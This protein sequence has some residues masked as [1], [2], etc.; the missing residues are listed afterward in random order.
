LGAQCIFF[1]LAAIAV[2]FTTITTIIACGPDIAGAVRDSVD[3]VFA[4]G[5]AAIHDFPAKAHLAHRLPH[6]VGVA[7]I[8]VAPSDVATVHGRV[9]GIDKTKL[10]VEAHGV[11]HIKRSTDVT[12]KSFRLLDAR[13]PP[14]S[15]SIRVVVSFCPPPDVGN[16]T[17]DARNKNFRVGNITRQGGD[18]CEVYVG[19]CANNPAELV[20]VAK[21]GVRIISPEGIVRVLPSLSILFC[22]TSVPRNN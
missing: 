8:H 13:T 22:C 2:G 1:T 14:V 12:T 19:T 17:S 5:L 21:T 9:F 18:V 6:D 20:L 3:K 7:G 11:G 16:C 10:G 4:I 15:V